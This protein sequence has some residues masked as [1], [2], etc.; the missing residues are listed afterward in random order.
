MSKTRKVNQRGRACEDYPCCGHEWGDCQ[1]WK[2]GTD[3]EI[4]QRHYAKLNSR[5]YDPYYDLE[6]Y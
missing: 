6:D 4:L 5:D 1:G 3:Q 2:Y